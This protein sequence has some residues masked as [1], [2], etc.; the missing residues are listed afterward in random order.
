MSGF[1]RRLVLAAG[2]VPVWGLFPFFGFAQSY[3]VK[4]VRIVVP[5]A[6]GGGVDN[7]A[8]AFAQKYTEAWKQPVI[9]ENRPGAGNIIG[10]DNVAKSAP[11]GYT[12]LVS[13][14][15]LASNAVLFRRLPFEIGRAHV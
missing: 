11:D 2:L 4:P 13:S 3:P 1:C 15:S 7:V 9:V 12:L 5:L 6:A 14:S 8:R 10:A